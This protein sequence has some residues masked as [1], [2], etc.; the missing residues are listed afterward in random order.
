MSKSRF[1]EQVTQKLTKLPG[2]PGCYI[3]RDAKGEVLYVG[4]ALVLKNRVRSYFQEST[5]HGLRIARMVSRVADIEWIVVDTE[6]EALVLECNL[7]KQYRPPFNVRLRD[8]KSYPYIKITNEKYPRLL[9]TRKV[10]KDGAKY[11][12]PYTS[13]FGV[14]DTLQLLHKIFPLIPCGKSWKGIREQSPCLYH[15][16]GRCLAPCAGIADLQEYKAVI[17]KVAR[18]LEGK[19]DSIVKD[20]KREMAAAAENLDFEKAAKIRDQL[21]AIEQLMERQKV[22][23]GDRTDR[24]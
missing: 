12:G 11:F 4:K 3:Y 1:P 22:L 17:E 9:F 10:L 13:A 24:T 21:Q 6:V 19:E 7:I 2:K 8:D 23:S 15:H 20:L 5:R 16:L 18:F 14:R